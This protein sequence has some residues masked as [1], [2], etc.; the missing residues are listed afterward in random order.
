MNDI[1]KTNA[2]ILCDRNLPQEV[3]DCD[4]PDFGDLEENLT[5]IFA[6]CEVATVRPLLS[7]RVLGRFIIFA[8]RIIRRCMSFYVTPIVTDQNKYNKLTSVCLE[9]VLFGMEELSERIKTLED[10][11]ANLR[12]FIGSME[13]N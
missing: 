12:R 11:N 13:H 5:L 3:R 8:K 6:N 2:G 1:E 7:E 10:E 9:D 4:S